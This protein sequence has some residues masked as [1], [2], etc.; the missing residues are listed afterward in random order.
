MAEVLFFHHVQGLTPGVIAL[1]DTLRA[2]G[3][4]VHTPDLFGGR[5]FG[6]IEEGIAHAEGLDRA[7]VDAEVDHIAAELPPG[8]VYAGISWGGASAQRLAQTR[9]GARGA[10]LLESFVPLSAPWSFGPW[11]E[12]VVVQVHGKAGD[13][14]VA[15][16]GDLEG[17]RE[18]VAGVGPGAELYVYPG[19]E[20]L[21]CDSSLPSS[22]PAA[23]ELLT[24][25][26][27]DLLRRV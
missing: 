13:P 22:D 19:D 23:T 8:L 9:P 27:L 7:R 21:F 11:P 17:A 16:E 12:G 14:F 20:H 3:H 15:G 4:T 5:V 6:S 2:A 24:A 1:A 25:R 18:L 10:V 26:V